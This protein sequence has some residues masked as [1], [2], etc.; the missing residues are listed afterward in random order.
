MGRIADKFSE[1]K[2][3]NEAALVLFFTAGDQPLSDLPAIVDALTEGGADVIE[4][5]IPFSD[6]PDA[7]PT[8]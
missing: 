5:G 4:V 1:L 7:L 3:R 6:P 8:D 2:A